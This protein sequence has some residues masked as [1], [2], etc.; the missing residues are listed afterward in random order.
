MPST[1]LS[2]SCAVGALLPLALACANQP[3]PPAK[4]AHAPLVAAPSPPAS[5]A[6]PRKAMRCAPQ[7]GF[8]ST[9]GG[10]GGAIVRVTTLAASGPGSLAEALA[11]AEPRLIVFEVGGVIDLAGQSID[12]KEPFVSV[13]G[14]TAPSP[15]ITLVRGGL[16]IR[17]HDV[18]VQHLR[19]RPGESGQAKGSGWE[20]DGITT[21][22][23]A[24][25]VIVD[26]CSVS[27]AT[28]ENLTASGGRFNGDTPAAWRQGTSHRIT[29]SNNLVAEG[30]SNS[31]H[32]KGE[33]SKGTLV[34]DN[35]TDMAVVRNL[36]LSN[37]ERNPFF[38]G[39]ARGIVVNNL[40]VNPKM[41]AMKYTLVADEW[42]EHPHQLG[43]MSVVGNVF[44]HGPDTAPGVPLVFASGVG[45]C[46]IY[47][48]DNLATDRAGKPVS[49]LG[50]AVNLF[51]EKTTP[52]TWP[53]ALEK[54]P[55]SAV[56][57]TISANAGGRP[58]E[59][60]AI[61]ARLVKEALES[62]GKII[63]AEVAVG[64]YPTAPATQAPF[65]A[66]AW[67]L[68]CLTRKAPADRAAPSTAISPSR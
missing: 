38:K 57:E 42:G 53:A 40:V 43:Q 51:V 34:H 25:D 6:A 4:P 35:V 26:H 3:A 29:F 20:V 2:C 59:R 46:E 16:K 50:G 55:A 61:D 62:G 31:T 7:L 67:D 17:T 39:G 21:S 14:Q 13:A 60:D 64:G 58:W 54:L 24:Y 66:S 37:V 22:S 27:W 44:N 8:T 47:L 36:F 30:L 65:D 63:D 9:R 28:D 45:Q 19:V 15:G 52:P 23:G 32:K 12:V 48:N 49:L 68:E 33:H 18:I 41:Y 10:Q 1:M 11:R 56:R 5:A